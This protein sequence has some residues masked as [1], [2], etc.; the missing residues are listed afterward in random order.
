MRSCGMVTQLGKLADSFQCGN[1]FSE[2]GKG[3]KLFA[4]FSSKSF[5][6][7]CRY[8]H[9]YI[10]RQPSRE[11]GQLTACFSRAFRHGFLD[12]KSTLHPVPV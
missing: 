6:H 3:G 9:T 12:L 2:S 11:L 8:I 7:D 4:S 10:D 1:K 5:L